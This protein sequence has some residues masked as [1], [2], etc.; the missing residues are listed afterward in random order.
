MDDNDNLHTSKLPQ[1][2]R[3]YAAEGLDRLGA[4][5][6]GL[7]GFP[8]SRPA[9]DFMVRQLRELL[10]AGGTWNGGVLARRIFGDG[11]TRK[12]RH[13]VAYARVHHHVHQIVG[14]PGSGYTWAEA[15]TEE[16]RKQLA[17]AVATATRMG[18]CFLY[19]ASL[20]RQQGTAMA[21]VQMVLD[22]MGEHAGD[23]KS[24]ELAALVASEGASVEQFLDAFVGTLAKTDKG[25]ATLAG[26]G[27]RHAAVLIPKDLLQGV[28]AQLEA[29][30]GQLRQAS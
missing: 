22:F 23:P 21:A 14:L 10:T 20:H 19:I 18:R 11:D 30:A 3:Q 2:F 29:A 27:A 1:H 16:G 28:A 12:V 15:D 9:L 24:D 17:R 4:D 25:R 8:R 5:P 6:L 13:L 7:S 26:V